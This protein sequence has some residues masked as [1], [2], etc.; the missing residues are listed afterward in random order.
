MEI[1]SR[2]FGLEGWLDDLPT[3]GRRRRIAQTA[4]LYHVATVLAP[5]VSAGQALARTQGQ[6][7]ALTQGQ[8]LALTQGQ[9]LALTQGQGLAL[10][11]E[12]G[13]RQRDPVPAEAEPT[14]ATVAAT[15]TATTT[16]TTAAATTTT[17]ATTTVASL[18]LGPWYDALELLVSVYRRGQGRID[19]EDNDHPTSTLNIIIDH[20]ADV[21]DRLPPPPA[22]P[23]ATTNRDSSSTQSVTFSSTAAAATATV[24]KTTKK[25]V[26][27]ADVLAQALMACAKGPPRAVRSSLH[28]C[29]R[30][31]KL[32]WQ[33]Y[34]KSRN[35]DYDD[36]KC[37][38]VNA[39]LHTPSPSTLALHVGQ[40]DVWDKINLVEHLGSMIDNDISQY[41]EEGSLAGTVDDEDCLRV[42]D[43]FFAAGIDAT[44]LNMVY[45]L[46]PP[47]PFEEVLY[48]VISFQTII[49]HHNNVI[50]CHLT[51][52]TCLLLL[53]Q[54]R[55]HCL[56]AFIHVMHTLIRSKKVTRHRVGIS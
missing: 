55:I 29:C 40:V 46:P 23:A 42:M 41:Y 45:D 9:G 18:P 44:M 13:Q 50:K 17:T 35:G 33:V 36:P 20:V 54:H 7:L 16:A 22:L 28:A 2:A 3:L 1:T 52:F 25:V 24:P 19:N 12:A 31:K 43:H 8:G 56:F 11:V 15:T 48:H 6:G 30:H 14:T 49:P 10:G 39:V 37:E 26:N 27:L 21:L 32:A 5:A 53:I 51:F 4:A 34:L 38:W 47:I